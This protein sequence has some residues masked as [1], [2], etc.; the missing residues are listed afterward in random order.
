MMWAVMV[1]VLACSALGFLSLLG[2]LVWTARPVLSPEVRDEYLT[3]V[4]AL[5]ASRQDPELA[6]EA[7]ARVTA[8]VLRPACPP[9]TAL[10]TAG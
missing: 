9:R 4:E 1:L 7:A 10:A 2:S 5:L 3:T 8:V 6:A